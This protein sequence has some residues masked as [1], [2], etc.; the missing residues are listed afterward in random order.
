MD[1]SKAFKRGVVKLTT[2][3]I[4]EGASKKRSCR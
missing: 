2:V 4:R 1:Y 3:N